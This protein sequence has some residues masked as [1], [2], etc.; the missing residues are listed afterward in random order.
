M[1]GKALEQNFGIRI[2]VL[3]HTEYYVNTL[4][5]SKANKDLEE[6][7]ELFNDLKNH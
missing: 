6:N 2:P 1:N 5:K 4:L 3:E 7:I